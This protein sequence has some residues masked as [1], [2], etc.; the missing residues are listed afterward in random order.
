MY[1]PKTKSVTI[2]GTPKNVFDAVLAHVELDKLTLVA[3]DEANLT[4][5]FAKGKTALSWGYE[6]V[7]SVAAAG[8]GST[9]QITCGGVDGAP[10]A[11]LDGMKHS[12]AADKALAA[13][14]ASVA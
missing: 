5:A 13:I 1:A 11:M 10:R 8:D 4:A 3:S 6:Y 9:L 14:A 7:A 12:K 2:A